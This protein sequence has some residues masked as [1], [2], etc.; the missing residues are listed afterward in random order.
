MAVSKC[1]L[2]SSTII[3]LICCSIL[4]ILSSILLSNKEGY[5][6]DGVLSLLDEKKVLLGKDK[7]D[8]DKIISKIKYQKKFAKIKT[9]EILLYNLCVFSYLIIRI[10]DIG[11]KCLIDIFLEIIIIFGYIV[12]VVLAS[13]TLKFYL[14]TFDDRKNVYYNY[15]NYKEVERDSYLVSDFDVMIMVFVILNL[16][17]H[18]IH[19]YIILKYIGCDEKP[20]CID[21]QFC[22]ICTCLN[23]CFHCFID[24]L[25]KC[26]GKICECL[27]DCCPA[28]CGKC[29]QCCGSFFNCLSDCC[30]SIC[31]GFSNCCSFCCGKCGHCCENLCNCLPDCCGS[32][33]KG[34]SNCCGSI[35]EGISDCCSVCC[36]KCGQC[37]AKC[38]GNDYDSLKKENDNL[39][40]KIN[41]LE[42]ENDSL[43]K[44]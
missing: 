13:M 12:D 6:Y 23:E 25:S 3:L 44:K 35:C 38:C 1:Q 4:I 14:Q 40:K 37:C 36:E 34:I 42:K 8:Y 32:L 21:T 10:K 31:E 18:L 20:E 5:G 39:R 22:F 28:C 24:C 17:F 30:G 33:C 2:L 7:K 11:A 9:I 27:S 16:I 41:E 19:F 43:K 29:G 26:C 15:Y